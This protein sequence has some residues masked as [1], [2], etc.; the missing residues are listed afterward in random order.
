MHGHPGLSSSGLN[1][2]P[3]GHLLFVR[4]CVQ[5]DESRLLAGP[6]R[7]PPGPLPAFC[8]DA[9]AAV[10]SVVKSLSGE[11][12][13]TWEVVATGPGVGQRRTAPQSWLKRMDVPRWQDTPVKPGDFVLLPDG[14]KRNLARGRGATGDTSEAFVDEV[15]AIAI[16]YPDKEQDDE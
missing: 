14:S 5:Y 1:I 6:A 11:H 4:A 13:N 2:L 9:D 10:A 8:R 7:K 12:G 16:L 15:E 3:T